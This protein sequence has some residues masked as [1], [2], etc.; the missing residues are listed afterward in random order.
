[1]IVPQHHHTAVK[2]LVFIDYLPGNP[3][4]RARINLCHLHCL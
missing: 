2:P 3:A 1:M 4:L